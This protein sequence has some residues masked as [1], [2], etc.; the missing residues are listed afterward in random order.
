MAGAEPLALIEARA[1]R[2]N[3][4]LQPAALGRVTIAVAEILP[5]A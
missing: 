3:D 2:A 5:K 1:M 4:V